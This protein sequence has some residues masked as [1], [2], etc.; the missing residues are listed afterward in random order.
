[1]YDNIIDIARRDFMVLCSKCKEELNTYTLNN[2]TFD[3]CPKC[4]SLFISKD[5]FKKLEENISLSV[6]KVDLFGLKPVKT[7]EQNKKCVYC[8]HDMVKI[9]YDGVI[10]DRC[11]KCEMLMF[12]NGELSKYFAKVSNDNIEIMNNARFLKSYI[13]NEQN[14]SKKENHDN[15]VTNIPIRSSN[16]K[17]QTK[18]VEKKVCA[19]DGWL[20]IGIMAC[21]I[22]I[23]GLI[24]ALIW[25]T[26][27]TPSALMFIIITVSLLIISGSF[28]ISGFIIVQ[29]Q[30]AV[31]LTL[32]GKYYGTL[33]NQ[34]FYWI[35]PFTNGKNNIISLKARTLDNGKQKI[36][37]I[38]GNPI[39]VGIMVTWEVSDTAKA[40]FNVNDFKTFLSAQCDS[41][42]RNIVRMYPYDV[43][44]DSDKQSLKGD[45]VEISE[46]LKREIQ[47]RVSVAGLNI[48]DAKITHLAYSSEIAMAMLQRQQANAVLDAK[49]AIVDGAVG[50]VE[51]VIERLS[52]NINLDDKTKASMVNNL[53]V[54]LCSSRDSQPV[55]RNDVL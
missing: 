18:E 44:E 40:V 48:I 45:S 9:Y 6:N 4:S 27:Q 41:A 52:R 53:L 12:D 49:R 39:E 28:I 13:N 25:T 1:M 20:A 21:A 55:I 43:P 24:Y 16:M 42:L 29:P 31:V 47:E 51:M 5:N 37:D 19:I 15:S 30:E 14:I 3:I 8:N 33:R 35:N 23:L 22:L 26:T 34:G 50:M 46:K 36:N 17:I 10:L 2:I 11:D 7:G 38:S 54:V 32:F